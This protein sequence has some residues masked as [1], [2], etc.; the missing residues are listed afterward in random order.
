MRVMRACVGGPVIG[1]WVIAVLWGI[2]SSQVRSREIN[3]RR[4]IDQ[5]RLRVDLQLLHG[6]PPGPSMDEG[7]GCPR[8][9]S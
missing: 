8:M 9:V 6:V 2:L 4:E 5:F 3:D 7:P 1:T